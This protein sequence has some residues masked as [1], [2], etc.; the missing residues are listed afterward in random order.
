ME[1]HTVFSTKS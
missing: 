1:N